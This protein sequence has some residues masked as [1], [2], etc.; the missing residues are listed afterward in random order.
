[1]AATFLLG[2]VPAQALITQPVTIDGPSSAVG[3][4]GG[5][6]MAVDGSGGLVYVKA[7]GGVPHVFAARFAE[8]SWAKPIQVDSSLPYEASEPRVAAG[9]KG[10]LLVVWVTQVATVKG[11]VRYGLYSAR[12]AGSSKVFSPPVPI[13]ANVGEGLG[14]DPSVVATGQ[15]KAIVAYRAVL[16]T[17][18]PTSPFT[19][20]VQLRPGD[21]L[22][23]IR[24]ARL[25]GDRW[26]Q[27]GAINVNTE[28]STRPPSD[29]NGP[30]VG[31][32]AEGGAVVAWQEPDV[33]GVARIYLRRIFG[34]TP[35]PPLQVS[36]STWEGNQVTAD[37]DAFSLS[38]T[39]YV[40]ARVAC[41]FTEATGSA[42]AG[43]LLVNTLPPNFS[44]EAAKLA[45]PQ[46]IGNPGEEPGPPS[47]ATVENSKRA[48]STTV[49]YVSGSRLRELAGTAQGAPAAVA[50]PG[51]PPA[52]PGTAA[53]TAADPEGGGLVAY[54]AVST[55][56]VPVVAVRQEFA[57]HSVQSGFLTGTEGG[58]VSELAIGRS[59]GGDGL[60][61][62]RQGEPGRYQ[63]VADHV[64]VPPTAFKLSVPKGWIKPDAAKLSWEAAPSAVGGLTYAVLVNGRTVKSGLRR[65]RFRPRPVQ[66]GDG[67]LRAQV[68]ATDLLG[69]QVLSAAAKLRVDAEP[70]TVRVAAHGDR[71]KVR[72]H[73][74]Q[75]GVKAKT[76][77]VSFGDGERERLGTGFSHSYGQP[78]SY[79]VVVQ[80]SDTVGNRVKRGFEVRVR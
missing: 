69:Q 74:G 80:A 62:F 22:A 45:G 26:S 17:F 24:V 38:V 54:P 70:P 5:V 71:V 56:G 39:P 77:L 76:T 32:G 49:A 59:G 72:I 14:V 61:G 47:I 33:S 37:A 2:S 12:L 18:S 79:R 9:P 75:S 1:V 34:T 55:T 27:L 16:N 8:G 21:V 65:L 28:A 73:D 6:A 52:Q 3:D 10:E 68:L 51:A 58:P 31:V 4:F 48:A 13:D 7:V 57:D 43:R 15:G 42:L 67:V 19:T 41:R 50:V 29:T 63:I 64:S 20:A 25:S 44:T 46:L 30:Q 40:M 11:K 66:L 35:G 23:E 36:P 53:L 78:G 60:V